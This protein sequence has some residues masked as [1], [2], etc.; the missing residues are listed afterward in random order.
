MKDA[1]GAG[2]ALPCKLH[3]GLSKSFNNHAAMITG[4]PGSQTPGHIGFQLFLRL[5]LILK[6]TI[7]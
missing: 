3:A 2:F 4:F 1:T 6:S 7:D 5:A